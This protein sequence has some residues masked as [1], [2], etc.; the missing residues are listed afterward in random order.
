M[1][2]TLTYAIRTATAPGETVPTLVPV[3]VDRKAPVSLTKVV[4]NAIDRGLIVGPKTSAAEE[5]ARGIADQM[6]KEF[7]NGNGV[8]FGQYFY[9]RLYLDGTTGA[10]GELTKA[11]K[12]NV[13]L[14]K[15]EEFR[16]SLNDFAF[17]YEGSADESKLDYLLS[18]GEGTSLPR[19]ELVEGMPVTAQ[20]THLRLDGDT[21]RLEF[22]ETGGGAA[23]DVTTFTAAGPDN[24]SFAW[25]AGL[26]AG[27]S[28]E[29]TVYRT[30]EDG[31]ERTSNSK[32]VTVRA[33]AVPPG[34]A[35]VTISGIDAEGTET[36]T[37]REN[38]PIRVHGTGLNL[39]EG[40][41]LYM[42]R[43][44]LGDDEYH[45]VPA[46]AISEAEDGTRLVLDDGEIEGEYFWGW[47]E[48]F[49]GFDS[50]HHGITLKLLSHGGDP[51][52][53]PQTVTANAQVVLS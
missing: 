3:I 53:E 32:R 17:T 28:Y 33:G 41:A 48:D 22:K 13:R 15:G 42:K 39:G 43:S 36:G 11:N 44:D 1:K 25:P 21:V 4:E 51:A 34:P 20:G 30:G 27:K 16:L 29:V 10:N 7:Q 40:D 18:K 52:S 26:V 19:N 23:V 9:G 49:G 37:V 12:V 47:F 5:I 8:A 6:Y 2:T 24:L 46:W 31:L 45:Q 38:A 14:Y 50:E 35:R